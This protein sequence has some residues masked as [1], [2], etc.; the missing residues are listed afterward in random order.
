MSGYKKWISV[1]NESFKDNNESSSFS[2]FYQATVATPKT[3]Q[4]RKKAQLHKAMANKSMPLSTA[5]A[6]PPTCP[7]VSSRNPHLNQTGPKDILLNWYK[8]KIKR[9][10]GDFMSR[11]GLTT[12]PT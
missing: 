5:S 10:M 9:M 7:K 12:T 3:Q 2:M 1:K 11:H 6:T 4:Q 8:A